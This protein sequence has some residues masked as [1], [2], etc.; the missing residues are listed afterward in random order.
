MNA[1]SMTEEVRK[2]PYGFWRVTTAMNSALVR[3]LVLALACDVAIMG[4]TFESP[5]IVMPDW[6]F[7]PFFALGIFSIFASVLF[8]LISGGQKNIMSIR[9]L[10][11]IPVWLFPIL[12]VTCVGSAIMF[13]K[14]F[15]SLAAGQPGYNAATQQYYY[16]DHGSITLTDRAHYLSAVVVQT[17]TFIGAAIIMT[18]VALAFAVAE[19]RLRRS[20]S[21]P[22]LRDIPIPRTPKPR[23]CPSPLASSLIGIVGLAFV[24]IWGAVIVERIDGYASNAPL[25][26]AGGIHQ[27]LGAGSWVVFVRCETT[28]IDA[29]YGCPTV[30]PAD[31]VIQEVA[32]GM[33]LPTLVDPSSDHISPNGLPAD[34]QLTFTVTKP[35]DYLLRTERPVPKG[36]FVAESPGQVARSLVPAIALTCVGL[37]V[38][39]LAVVSISRRVRWRLRFAPPAEVP[40][41]KGL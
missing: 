17:R 1:V 19:A 20:V 16:D 15:N 25:I 8:G 24:G 14:S 18:S 9:K 37:L 22:R 23:R 28:Q 39:L 2:I 32:T 11:H 7:A 12:A 3:L 36:I 6:I 5:R 10:S 29:E 21:V 35:G 33:A 40:I 26:T 13:T 4:F 27:H 38:A 30:L 41:A 31:V 34:G